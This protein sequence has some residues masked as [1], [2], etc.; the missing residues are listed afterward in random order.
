MVF[1][2]LEARH[3]ASRRPPLP[4]PGPS[5]MTRNCS[6][7]RSPLFPEPA[8]LAASFSRAPRGRGR[9]R[10]GVSRP[11]GLRWFKNASASPRRHLFPPG[12]GTG[13]GVRWFRGRPA[14]LGASLGASTPRPSRGRAASSPKLALRGSEAHP[15]E[16]SLVTP[17]QNPGRGA[18]AGR[19][20][21]PG[22]DVEAEPL[23]WRDPRTAGKQV[24]VSRP[25]DSGSGLPSPW[26]LLP[27]TTPSR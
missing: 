3:E 13:G 10:R 20:R 15:K 8:A 17:G 7:G 25:P 23:P 12:D 27:A 2:V 6:S 1:R 5:G 4:V 11:S 9:P 26:R 18:K 19:T 16:G 14:S 22:R 21:L 24:A